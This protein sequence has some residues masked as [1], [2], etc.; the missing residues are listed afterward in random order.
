V[1]GEHVAK[2]KA[3]AWHAAGR[4]GN[5]IRV[6][7]IDSFSSAHWNAAIASGDL[8]TPAGVFCLAN[9]VVCD[10]W[11]QPP[12]THGVAVAEVVHDVAPGAQL[13]LAGVTHSSAADLR[14]AVDYFAS[15]G[16]RVITR[17]LTAAYDGPGN[18]TG[19]IASVIDYAVSKGI[20]WFNS[21]GNS[22]GS[23]PTTPGGYWRGVWADA[24]GNGWLDFRPGD[25]VLD[26]QCGYTLGLRWSDWAPAGR[27]DY[28]IRV[29][30]DPALTVLHAVGTNTQSSTVAPLEHVADYCSGKDDIDYLAVGLASAGSGTAGDVLEFMTNSKIIDPYW[31]NPY[32]ATQPASD[33][34]SAGALSIGAVDPALGTTIASYSSQGPTNDG[35]MKPDLSA[36][37]CVTTR[38]QG[39]FNGT[40]AATPV[41]AGAAALY[42]GANPAATPAQV[43]NF[44]LTQAF[45]DR[46]AAGPD[47]VYGVGE[48][49]LPP[50]AAPPRPPPPTPPPLPPPSTPPL[51]PAPGLDRTPPTV[52]AYRT[53]A[54]LGRPAKL[55]YRVFDNSG[56]TWELVQVLR[57]QTRVTSIRT[58]FGPTGRTGQV[59]SVTWRAPRRG[60]GPWRFCV[61]SS[62]RR[63]NKSRLSCAPIVMRS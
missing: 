32:S 5:G 30:D 42:L 55:R 47:N 29:Y 51:P 2:T 15:Q 18:G 43:K 56:Q 60:R 37:S 26:F 52:R 40:S 44:L 25:E 21:A 12:E 11:A 14:A 38:T 33:S 35:R 6:G 61:R 16:V 53:T 28:D 48:L 24:N 27:T 62:D 8:P 41:A 50:L 31:S 10:I 57:R 23:G 1:T 54:R 63:G 59:Y 20:V 9:G 45:V 39:C 19:P 17:S 49:V 46:G 3:G 36:A 7:I 4:R 34:A 58:R 22:A 13:F